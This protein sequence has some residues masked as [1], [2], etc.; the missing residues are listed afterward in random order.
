MVRRKSIQATELDKQLTEAVLGVQSGK[1]KS[2][3]EAA[4]QL[5]LNRRSVT[6]RVHGG[7]SRVQARQQQQKLSPTQEKTLLKWIKQL[8]I[9][10]YSPSHSLLKEIA[11]EVRTNQSRDLD[12]PAFIESNPSSNLPL[13]QDW[14]PRFIKRHPHLTVAIGRR[15]ESV[16]MDGATKLILVA[17]FNA[18]NEVVTTQKILSEKHIQYG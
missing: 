1:Y 4:K 2:S 17:W 18:Y 6:R 10:G 15:I 13:G 7:L 9:S 12:Y 11:E 16:R 14:V 5:G 3:Y 8:T